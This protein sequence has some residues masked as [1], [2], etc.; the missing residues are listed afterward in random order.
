MCRLR[1]S[2]AQRL[3]P[4]HPPPHANPFSPKPARP[5]PAQEGPGPP[6]LLAVPVSEMCSAYARLL[7]PKITQ[8]A[9]HVTNSS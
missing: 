5:L 6:A 9:W 4:P 8:W 1:V 2:G 3:P 7:Q